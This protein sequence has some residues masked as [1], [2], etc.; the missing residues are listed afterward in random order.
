M[1]LPGFCARRALFPL[2]GAGYSGRAV[3]LRFK[4]HTTPGLPD[5]ERRVLM[6]ELGARLIPFQS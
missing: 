3:Q 5:A 1:T 6:G 4:L 2:R